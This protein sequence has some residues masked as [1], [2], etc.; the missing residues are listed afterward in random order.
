[1]ASNSLQLAKNLLR[2]G[3]K[4][5]L[6]LPSG[7]GATK[8]APGNVFKHVYLDVPTSAAMR[9]ALDA[10]GDSRLT[11]HLLP[12]DHSHTT[13]TDLVVPEN[14]LTKIEHGTLITKTGAGKLVFNGPVEAP[15]TQWLS[16]FSD[17]DVE[18]NHPSTQVNPA[19]FGEAE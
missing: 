1:M 4:P 15:P 2:L 16:G 11:L 7:Y 12:A 3:V 17:G 10:V 14:V 13:D 8:A 9:S 18:F 19:W 6:L 5:D